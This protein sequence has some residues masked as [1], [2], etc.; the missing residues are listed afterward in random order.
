MLAGVVDPKKFGTAGFAAAFSAGFPKPP[1]R[2]P[3]AA[4]AGVLAVCAGAPPK[5]DAA[6]AVP[7]GFAPNIPPPAGAAAGVAPGA[8]VPVDVVG[9]V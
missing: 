7:A 8:G 4:G 6:G 9:W 5:K 1:K 3:P 2:A